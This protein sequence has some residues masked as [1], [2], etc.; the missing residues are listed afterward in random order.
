MTELLFRDDAYRR[1]AEVEV[2][3]AAPGRI[4]LDSTI[5]YAQ[6]GGQPGDRGELALADGSTIT[7]T[8]TVY[9]ADRKTIA[10]VPTEGARLPPPGERVTAEVVGYL[11]ELTSAGARLHGA[12]DP[13]IERQTQD[14]GSRQ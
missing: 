12:A 8:N 4:V 7:V 14:P 5:F 9:D 1:E 13:E 10:H 3:E 6:G 2:I 11:R